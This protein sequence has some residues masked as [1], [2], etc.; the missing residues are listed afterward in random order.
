[1]T[2]ETMATLVEIIADGQL[3]WVF[4]PWNGFRF[5]DEGYEWDDSFDRFIVEQ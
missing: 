3:A 4:I 5:P 2:D 1:M